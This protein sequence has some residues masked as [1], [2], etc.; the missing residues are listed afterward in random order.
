MLSSYFDLRACRQA[1]ERQE[2]R[3]REERRQDE[4]RRREERRQDEERRRQD[5]E[6]TER[7]HHELMALMVAALSSDRNQG[8]GQSELIR[9]LQQTIEELRAENDGLRR[10]NGNG[11][12]DC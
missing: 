1:E 10:Q 2:E 12:S 3:R 5:A 4:E 8:N 6:A 9:N 7:R 11:D